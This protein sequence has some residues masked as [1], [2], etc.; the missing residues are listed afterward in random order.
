M[1][2]GFNGVNNLDIDRLTTM[3]E[4]N[5]TLL[6]EMATTETDSEGACLP[7]LLFEIVKEANNEDDTSETLNES[8]DEMDAARSNLR[9]S[10][11]QEIIGN[12]PKVWRVLMELLNHQKIAQVEFQENGQ[13]EDCYKSIQTP[14]GPKVELS[15]S[16][17]YIKLKVSY[18]LH[19]YCLFPSLSQ[20]FLRNIDRNKF[21]SCIL[22]Y[23][24]SGPNFGEKGATK[25][26][27]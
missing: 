2:T 13:G 19:V 7:K 25:G 20:I 24:C 6:N 14:T 4:E 15:V 21:N 26:N 17:T 18:T 5:R 8:S 11:S 3:L 10:S 22:F 23:S 1:L 9:L 27:Y 12:L 16:K